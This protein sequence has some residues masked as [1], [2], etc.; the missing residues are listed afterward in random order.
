M[1]CEQLCVKYY[2]KLL[3]QYP[4]HML[5]FSRS[6]TGDVERSQAKTLVKLVQ[7]ISPSTPPTSHTFNTSNSPLSVSLSPTH[8]SSLTPSL[9]PSRTSEAEGRSPLNTASHICAR[10]R[11]QMRTHTHPYAIPHTREALAKP[12]LINDT[13]HCVRREGWVCDVWWGQ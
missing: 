4:I 8:S 7:L 2:S 5:F 11:T 9:L 1:K 13:R 12:C 10:I 3:Y 6:P